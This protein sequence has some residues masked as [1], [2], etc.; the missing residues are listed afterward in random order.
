MPIVDTGDGSFDANAQ[1]VEDAKIEQAKAD[2][3]DESGAGEGELILW[4]VAPPRS[5]PMHTKACSGKQ[6]AEGRAARA[7]S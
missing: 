4:Q 3:V 6:Q 1:A 2:L 7:S 5:W